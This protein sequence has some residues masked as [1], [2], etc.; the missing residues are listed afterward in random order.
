MTT[1]L[2]PIPSQEGSMMLPS[3]S[4]ESDGPVGSTG[5]YFVEVHMTVNGTP[6]TDAP[7]ALAI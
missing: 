1:Y 4:F 7:G 6:I 3:F 5:Y 2:A